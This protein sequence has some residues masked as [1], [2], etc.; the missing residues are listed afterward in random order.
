MFNLVLTNWMQISKSKQFHKATLHVNADGT[1][2]LKSPK[3]EYN[4]VALKEK[5][6]NLI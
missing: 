3:S 5:K 4:P 2:K 1:F 6:K